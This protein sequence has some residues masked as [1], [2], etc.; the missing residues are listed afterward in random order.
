MHHFILTT[1]L[2]WEMF[3]II[4]SRKPA[5]DF[6]KIVKASTSP[7]STFSSQRIECEKSRKNGIFV[8]DVKTKTLIIFIYNPDD[9]SPY[10]SY[11]ISVP[12][13]TDLY[14]AFVQLPSTYYD[15]GIMALM[16]EYYIS[17]V[18]AA[19][20]GT[21]GIP[22]ISQISK[23]FD[24]MILYPLENQPTL[25]NEMLTQLYPLVSNQYVPTSEALT[26]IRRGCMMEKI[27]GFMIGDD[28]Y[29]SYAY[30]SSHS[31]HVAFRSYYHTHI[32]IWTWV[33]NQMVWEEVEVGLIH[34]GHRSPQDRVYHAI[35]LPPIRAAPA[36]YPCIDPNGIRSRI[37][38]L[39]NNEQP[40]GVAPFRM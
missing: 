16:A 33:N 18:N 23:M 19:Y 12:Q 22:C 1:A 25:F 14:E 35:P 30:T 8:D 29:M 2:T 21:P 24:H 15:L 38:F 6:V 13:D 17:P 20:H 9:V 4:A 39:D 34:G 28:D 32:M 10:G 3:I 26:R 31:Y 7:G 36:A 5:S 37:T 11:N 27:S 40:L